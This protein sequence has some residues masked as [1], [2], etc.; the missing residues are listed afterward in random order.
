MENQQDEF[1]IK[2]TSA[3]RRIFDLKKRI[4]A[5]TGGTAASKTIS[6][7]I[8]LIDYCQSQKNKDKLATVV[9]ESYPHL[10]KGAMRDFEVIMK[11]RGYW[12]DRLWNNTKHIYTFETGNKL[13][14]MS[15][16]TYGKAHGPRR[17]ILFVNECNNLAYN[18]VDQLIIRTKEV[19]WLD[20][21]PVAE[22][23]FYTDMMITREKDLDFITLTY[24]DNEALDQITI[25]EIE[26]HRN[27]KAWWTVYGL[28]QL[29]QLEGRI[30][31][32]WQIIN[33]IPHEARLER[34]GLDFG[35]SNDPTVIIAIY[36]YN[37]GFILDEITYQKGLSNKTIADT[38]INQPRALVIA[39]SAEPKSIDEIKGYGVN[40]IGAIKGA[41]SV[42][43]GIQYVQ[44]QKISITERS[45]KSI[46]AYR[47]YLFI[48]DKDGKVINDPDDT[49]HEWSN[50]MDAVR[51]GLDSFKPRLNIKPQTDFGGIKSHIPG[52]LA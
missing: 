23:W 34:Y 24:K 11:D 50:S 45:I 38:F 17:H 3:T 35:Y 40:I 18:I 33:Q 20:W 37:D 22:F 4:R 7:L 8:W 5:V 13:E 9:S 48:T 32:N 36:R 52:L 12:K 16:D 41:D 27:N 30:Y 10:E 6:I 21:N 43:Q 31:T 28:G 2:D 49:I 26:S 19:I 1:H 44:N 39:D 51:Y 25:D 14:F 29:G 47:N 46:K 42:Y 15:V